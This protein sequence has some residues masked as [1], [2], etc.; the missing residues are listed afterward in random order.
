ML[1]LPNNIPCTELCTEAKRL[2]NTNLLGGRTLRSAETPLILVP[3]H[4]IGERGRWH[5][6]MAENRPPQI[7]CCAVICM[8][9]GSIECG[10]L[11]KGVHRQLS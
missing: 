7:F 3:C 1:M 9:L 10:G 2:W 8:L 6:P 11:Y 4:F 5:V